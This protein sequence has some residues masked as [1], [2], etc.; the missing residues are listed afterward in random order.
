MLFSAS[1]Y[2]PVELYSSIVGAVLYSSCSPFLSICIVTTS[3]F[4][5]F[6]I[7]FISD[8]FFT[9]FP[10]I[11]FIVSPGIIPTDSAEYP[12]VH[13]STVVVTLFGVAV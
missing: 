5:E 1:K 2:I 9:L 13:E 6:I 7:L 11:F 12:D 3:P 10:F 8:C 4:D